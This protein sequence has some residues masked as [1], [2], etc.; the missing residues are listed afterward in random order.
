MEPLEL[1]E[2]HPRPSHEAQRQAINRRVASSSRHPVDQVWALIRL[3]LEGHPFVATLLLFGVIGVLL[4]FL[5]SA[6]RRPIA[7]HR[8]SHDYTKI[9]YDYNFRASQMQ[10]WCLFV[11]YFAHH[12][13]HP[14]GTT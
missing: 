14:C 8:I 1:E 11:S 13:I 5:V 3:Y 9:N 12:I 6:M 10:H 2:L 4:H 7:R